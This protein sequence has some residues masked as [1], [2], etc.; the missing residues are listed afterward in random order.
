MFLRPEYGAT[1][2]VEGRITHPAVPGPS[3]YH[4][5]D[6][7]LVA[8]GPGITPG[9]HPEASIAD[10]APTLLTALGVAPPAHMEA[11]AVPWLVPSSDDLRSVRSKPEESVAG[12]LTTG[13]ED[14]IQQHLRELGYVD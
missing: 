14:L 2:R 4:E 11:T 12:R 7:I 8:S 10:I 5:P 1:G 13:E 9:S 6:G 3:G